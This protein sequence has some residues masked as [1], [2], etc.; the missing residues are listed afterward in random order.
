MKNLVLISLFFVGIVFAEPVLPIL[1][2][3]FSI[4]TAEAAVRVSGYYRKNG[5]Y[6]APHYR[7]NPDGNPYNNWS[8]PGNT[9]PYTGKTATGNPSTYLNDYRRTGTYSPKSYA[10]PFSNDTFNS[11]D[12]FDEIYKQLLNRNKP[13][14]TYTSPSLR[15]SIFN[16]LT[17]TSNTCGSHGKFDHYSSAGLQICKCDT[18]YW[19]SNGV[20]VIAGSNGVTEEEIDCGYGGAYNVSKGT[21]DC[22]SG[23]LY[24]KGKCQSPH[25]CGLVGTYNWDTEEC[26][27]ASGYQLQFGY[28]SRV[29]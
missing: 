23:Y 1:S 10:S 18:G 9:N 20:C 17:R 24:R 28:C 3:L 21:C 27:C 16:S 5:T 6:V 22:R 14:T 29:Y 25:Y 13:S 2:P 19:S 7:S 15:G 8:Y 11:E 12:S 26:D 4:E